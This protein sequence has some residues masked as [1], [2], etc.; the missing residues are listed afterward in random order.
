MLQKEN[1]PIKNGQRL[2]QLYHQIVLEKKLN[3]IREMRNKTTV[4]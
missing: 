4:R 2:E 3:I 1:R